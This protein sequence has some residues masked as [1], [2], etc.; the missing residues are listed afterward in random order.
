MVLAGSDVKSESLESRLELLERRVV[1]TL[2]EP[3]R[4][5][6]TLD[7]ALQDLVHSVK[8]QGLEGLVPT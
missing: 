1:P 6:G 4:Y 2:I 7:A 3:V 8:V 5:T